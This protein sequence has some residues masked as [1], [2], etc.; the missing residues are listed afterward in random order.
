MM[1][2]NL[3]NGASTCYNILVLPNYSCTGSTLR[4]TTDRIHTVFSGRYLTIGR[5]KVLADLAEETLAD[6][7]VVK[8]H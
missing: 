2:F 3:Y 1:R 8:N 5:C 7:A 6:L 4:V